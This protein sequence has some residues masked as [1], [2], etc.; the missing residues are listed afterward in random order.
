MNPNPP[1][2]PPGPGLAFGQRE[3]DQPQVQDADRHKRSPERR[4]V[5]G[6][7]V[8]QPPASDRVQVGLGDRQPGQIVRQELIRDRQEPGE[9]AG[10][11]QAQRHH[12]EQAAAVL[13]DRHQEARF[14]ECANHDR[15]P[16]E[17]ASM[18]SAATG[19]G[20]VK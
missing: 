11:Q 1:Q 9:P 20:V 8:D 17:P 16:S 10:G 4:P 12:R 5:V 2:E 15:R 3:A 7:E 19:R 6:H 13:P 14:V 18:A